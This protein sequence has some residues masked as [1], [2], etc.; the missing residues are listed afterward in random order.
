MVWLGH[1]TSIALAV[2]CRPR[3]ALAYGMLT[4]ATGIGIS[5]YWGVAALQTTIDAPPFV[6]AAIYAALTGFEAIAFGLFSCLASLFARRSAALVALIPAAWVTIEYWFPRIFPWQ[7]G[8]S[9]LELLPLIQI[10]E[11]VG[12][13]GIGFVMT[14]AAAIPAA[15]LVL[16]RSDRAVRGWCLAYTAG[17]MLLLMLTLV[18]GEARRRQW[19]AWAAQQPLLKTALL[20]V[21]P[22]YIGFDAKLRERSLAVHTEVDLICW[23]ESA[24]GTY[25]DKLDHFRDA[26]LTLRLSRDSTDSLEP[27]KD[28]HCHLL[29][30]GK[31]YGPAAGEDGPYAMTA[32]L[33][34]PTQD[35]LGRYRKRTLLPFGEYVPGQSFLPEIRHWATLRDVI[36][37]GDSAAPLAMTNDNRLGV[38]IC[39]EDML[40]ANARRTVAAGSDVLI[41]IIQGA[42]FDNPLTLEQHERLARMRAVENRRYFARCASTGV[43]CLIS[44]TGETL[45]RLP[46]Q[47]EQTLRA[48]IP[49]LHTRTL[50]NL[51]GD[52]FP[53]SCSLAVALGLI[54]VRR[55]PSAKAL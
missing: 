42:A 37:A 43:T 25:S 11:F 41:S 39:Y 22:T 6:A 10:A 45:A 49:L 19:D 52:F 7:L 3:P 35:I 48:D 28:L 5:F 54:F 47:V 20:Q 14:A 2:S 9:Q 23:P 26:S 38:L 18:G 1:A 44:A 24:L 33:I 8:Y 51:G 15:W 30:G 12:S 34:A 50:Y 21:D 36:E 27:A 31:L 40:P 29:G 17:A 4:G 32:F 46:P 55:S 16:R 53:W 13:T